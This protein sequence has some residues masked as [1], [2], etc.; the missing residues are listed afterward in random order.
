LGDGKFEKGKILISSWNVNGL[1]AFVKKPNFKKYMKQNDPDIICFNE[2]KINLD[3]LK[4]AT[5]NPDF[6]SATKP[7]TMFWNFSTARKGYAGTSIFTKQKPITV[8]NGINC[9][10]HDME[11]R[12]ITA[13]FEKFY[14]VA[15][16]I[17]N[18]GQGLKRLDYRVDKWD[19]DMH[20]YLNGLKDKKNVVWCGD[21][22]V[23]HKDIDIYKTKGMHRCAGFTPQ[24]RKNF[25]KFLK[26][27][28]I[29]TFRH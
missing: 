19:E 17:P 27:G 7:Y 3:T 8:T 25:G 9:P 13:E 5:S 1:R 16:Y 11:G 4:V 6:I 26:Q 29:D 12:I 28:W 23:A 20:K 10:E 22:N 21:L 24:E 14:L 18:A 2:T 15:S